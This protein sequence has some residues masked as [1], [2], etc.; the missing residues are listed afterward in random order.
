MLK[1][2]ELLFILQ[3]R[4]YIYDYYCPAKVLHEKK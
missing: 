3:S 4:L 2:V 1:L